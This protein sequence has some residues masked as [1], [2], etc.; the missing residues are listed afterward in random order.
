MSLSQPPRAGVGIGYVEVR[1]FGEGRFW[2][3]NAWWAFLR[4]DNLGWGVGDRVRIWNLCH[5]MTLFP[6]T[7]DQSQAAL[8]CD[9]FSGGQAQAV[10][11]FCNIK[12]RISGLPVL[13]QDSI[14]L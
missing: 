5:I 4:V 10:P 12:C 7:P 13:A 14:A 9:T 11:N 6:G 2:S 8:I 3:R 1:T